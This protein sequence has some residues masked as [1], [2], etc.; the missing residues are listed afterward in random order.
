[1][2]LTSISGIPLFTTVAEAEQWALANSLSGFHIHIYS[3]QTGYMGGANHA[4]AISST[5]NTN[6]IPP[7]SSTSGGGGGGY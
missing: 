5:M 6:L 1:M 7:S 4:S 3:G 2:I